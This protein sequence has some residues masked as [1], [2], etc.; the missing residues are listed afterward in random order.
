MHT[1]AAPAFWRGNKCHSGELFVLRV[2]H[3]LTPRGGA[4]AIPNFGGSL[5]FMRTSFCRRTTKFEVVTCVGRGK[6]LGVNYAGLLSQQ[7][8][9]PGLPNLLGSPVLIPTPFNAKRP[10]HAK[11]IWGRAC[12]TRSATPLRLHK[13]VARFVS[14]DR[15]C[16]WT[17]GEW[18]TEW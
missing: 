12:F 15:V 17:W 2:C 14:D 7:M 1:P 10:K 11:H 18:V 13:S 3:A 9:V 16:C 8:G 6:Y 5:L 4:P